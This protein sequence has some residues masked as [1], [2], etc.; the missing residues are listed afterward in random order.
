MKVSKLFSALFG[1]LAACTAVIAVFLSFSLRNAAPIL[2]TPPQEARSQV[3]GLMDALCAGDYDGVSDRLLGNPGLGIDRPAAEEIGVSIWESFVDS[4][5]Y[6]LAGECYIT[7]AGLAQDVFIT[8]L[9]MTD[10]T[11]DL[12]EKA[13]VLL[14]ERVENAGSI[15][16]IYD[17]NNEYRE[18]FV[19][20]VLRD[21]ALAQLESAGTNTTK[22]TLNLSYQ[23]GKW[24]VVADSA[25]LDAISGGILY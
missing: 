15:S 25:L 9:D 1:I 16:D 20:G 22:L 21:A 23:N 11:D 4:L 5:S 12:R 24:W 6:E 19:M 18:D 17:E 10:V 8:G 3:I 14:E 13:Q 7:E 2:L